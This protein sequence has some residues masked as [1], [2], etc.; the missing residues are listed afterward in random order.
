M[1]ICNVQLTQKRMH[2]KRLDACVSDITETKERGKG[3]WT[4]K[5]SDV[6]SLTLLVCGRTAMF[7]RYIFLNLLHISIRVANTYEY[8]DIAKGITIHMYWALMISMLSV[9]ISGQAAEKNLAPG[10]PLLMV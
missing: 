9:Y 8:I 2:R 10:K 1:R 5:C 3:S 6:Y 7:A 4:P